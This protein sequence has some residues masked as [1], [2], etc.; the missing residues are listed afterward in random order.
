MNKAQKESLDMHDTTCRF[1]PNQHWPRLVLCTVE[2]GLSL[3]LLP[4]HRL[5]QMARLLHP[6]CAGY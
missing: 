3:E 1:I 6:L 4:L 2:K 5:K